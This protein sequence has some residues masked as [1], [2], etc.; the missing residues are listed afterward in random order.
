MNTETK[1]L[2]KLNLRVSPDVAEGLERLAKADART[3]CG[4]MRL[5]LAEHVRAELE[6]LELNGGRKPR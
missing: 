1:H 6:Y 2:V 5:V 4:Y 3:L